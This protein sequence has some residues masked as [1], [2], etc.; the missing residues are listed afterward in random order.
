MRDV[1]KTIGNMIDKL[2]IAF[3]VR[4]MKKASQM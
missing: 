3:R 4:W 2:K 1:E